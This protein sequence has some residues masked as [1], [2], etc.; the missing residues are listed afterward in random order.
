MMAMALEIIWDLLEREKR[1]PKPEKENNETED[2][3]CYRHCLPPMQSV[4]GS[5]CD[6]TS[7]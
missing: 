7:G 4:C 5:L 3:L 6:Q 2:R 1:E